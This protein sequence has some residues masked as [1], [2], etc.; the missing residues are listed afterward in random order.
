MHLTFEPGEPM[1]NCAWVLVHTWPSLLLIPTIKWKRKDC[2][3]S[4]LIGGTDK[5]QPYSLPPTFVFWEPPDVRV[6]WYYDED[7]LVSG[8]G[9]VLP[10]NTF[11]GRAEFIAWRLRRHNM[12]SADEIKYFCDGH[13]YLDS[14]VAPQSNDLVSNPDLVGSR[15][16][17]AIIT[18]AIL[19]QI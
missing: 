10:D 11:F 3:K 14:C 8:V 6:G 7:R 18:W 4:Y 13:A 15:I 2:L 19:R 1:T 5:Y 16:N 17:T 9:C 12:G